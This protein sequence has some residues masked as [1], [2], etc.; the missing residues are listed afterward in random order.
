MKKEALLEAI[1]QK[2]WFTELARFVGYRG[3]TLRDLQ[4]RIE[5]LSAQ[6][7]KRQLEQAAYWLVQ[8]EGQNTVTPKPLTHV[9]LRPEV[10]NGCYMLLSPAPEP[11]E[12]FY[13]CADGSPA[14][15]PEGKEDRP[16]KRPQPSAKPKKPDPTP[17]KAEAKPAIRE[18]P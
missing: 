11:E 3:C 10:R 16:G 1:Y 9:S 7:D 13:T 18:Q 6:Y 15:R 8:Y 4:A 14:P 2:P 12:A 5:L 17:A